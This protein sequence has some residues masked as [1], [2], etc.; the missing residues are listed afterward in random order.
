VAARGLRERL[1]RL[2]QALDLRGVDVIGAWTAGMRELKDK[3][4]SL[5]V[6][7]QKRALCSFNVGDYCRLHSAPKAGPIQE[8]L[9]FDRSA[10]TSESH[11]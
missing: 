8:S 7:T 1:L 9:C 4:H 10:D 6:A 5:L 2:C 11:Y 3:E